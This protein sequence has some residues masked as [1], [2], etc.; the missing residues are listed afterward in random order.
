MYRIGIVGLGVIYQQYILALAGMDDCFRLV[1]VCDNNETRLVQGLQLVHETLQPNGIQGYTDLKNFLSTSDMDLV[2]IATPPSTH[3]SIAI[4]CIQAGK[5]FLMEKP[6]TCRLD[7]FVEIQKLCSLQALQFHTAFH[8]AYAADLL[9]FVSHQKELEQKFNL[10][11]IAAIACG[12]YDP[13][14]ANGQI[15][16]GRE[17]LGGSFLDSGINELSVIARLVDIDSLRV[18]THYL[19]RLPSLGIICK[20]S[21]TLEKI[22]DDLVIHLKTDWTLGKNEKTTLIE[23][24]TGS[25]ILLNHSLQTVTLQKGDTT[26]MLFDNGTKP[27]LLTQY[28]NLLKDF[29]LFLDAH[30]SNCQKSLQIH[31]LLLDCSKSSSNIL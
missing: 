26:T 14:V 11:K 19:E 25:K 2:F 15:T 10:G 4:K 9:W 23:Y 18:K 13:Y 27:R 29:I 16:V 8:S 5:S 6:A 24:D 22:Q 17:A 31:R 3:H 7:D 12:F 30:L 21:T 20:S 28:I 1:A